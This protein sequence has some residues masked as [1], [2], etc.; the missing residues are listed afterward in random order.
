MF[1]KAAGDD[2]FSWRLP[3]YA[4]VG[5]FILF[6]PA[7][8][9]VPDMSLLAYLF[10]V[11]IVSL[12]LI[13]FL[14]KEAIARRTRRCLSVLSMLVVVWAVSAVLAANQTTI[15]NVARWLVWS[16]DYKARVLSAYGMG[17]LG[18]GRTGHHGVPCFRS[19]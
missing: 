12:T 10:G 11:L 7:A 4:V 8:F 6:L 14:V 15:R 3:L 18:L 17:R 19:D 5:D 16:Q 2:R 13:A 1:G 9:F